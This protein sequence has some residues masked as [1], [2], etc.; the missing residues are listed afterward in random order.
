MEAHMV[1]LVVEPRDK[2]VVVTFAA[3]RLGYEELD[4]WGEQLCETS[5]Y[6]PGRVIILDMSSVMTLSSVAL[7][8]LFKARKLSMAT[9]GE[10]KIVAT[11]EAVLEVF[12]AC[13]I[14]RLF[15]IYDSVEGALASIA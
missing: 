14:D 1:N 3:S 4:S 9:D 13:Q 6:F 15:G 8:K 5:D 12:A 7:G 11:S 10:M 2:A